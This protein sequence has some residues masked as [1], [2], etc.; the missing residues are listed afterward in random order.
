MTACITVQPLA[1]RVSVDVIFSFLLLVSTGQEQKNKYYI[2][3]SIY[4]SLQKWNIKIDKDQ[5][6]AWINTIGEECA[7]LTHFDV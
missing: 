3:S 4:L 1:S 2:G 5:N 6:S 7:L